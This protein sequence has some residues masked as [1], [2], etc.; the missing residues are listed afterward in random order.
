M[1]QGLSVGLKAREAQLPSFVCVG[2]AWI[3]AAHYIAAACLSHP[4]LRSAE[5]RRGSLHPTA[6]QFHKTINGDRRG[7]RRNVPNGS[8]AGARRG[9]ALISL[10][11]PCFR[12]ETADSTGM[13]IVKIIARSLP[14]PIA[15]NPPPPHI[16]KAALQFK[17][18]RLYT[19]DGPRNRYPP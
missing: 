7:Q 4:P 17:R 13:G 16:P 18:Q 10:F 14:P 1:Q 6:P 5:E 3:Q 8:P 11:A 19:R 12:P 2:P 9:P 15:P